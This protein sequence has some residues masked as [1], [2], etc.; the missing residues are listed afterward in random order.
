MLL[1]NNALKCQ[2]SVCGVVLNDSFS[3]DISFSST[4][5]HFFQ[6][7][8]RSDCKFKY[9]KSMHI[10]SERL[11]CVKECASWLFFSKTRFCFFAHCGNKCLS[12]PEANVKFCKVLFF[13]CALSYTS[14]WKASR[15]DFGQVTCFWGELGTFTYVRDDIHICL[16]ADIFTS[17]VKVGWICSG[18]YSGHPVSRLHCFES[19]LDVRGEPVGDA[20]CH[21]VKWRVYNWL[22]PLIFF[23]F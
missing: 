6:N 7:D 5:V 4:S 16:T 23:P 11:D 1:K 10:S 12:D 22:C 2:F 17:W 15:W 18:S 20:T 13:Q 21:T 9:F 14:Q 3:Y 19:I 8:F